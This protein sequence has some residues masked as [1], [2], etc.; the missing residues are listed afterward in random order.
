MKLFSMDYKDMTF[1]DAQWQHFLEAV[2]ILLVFFTIAFLAGGLGGCAY[3]S[4]SYPRCTKT[5][6][7]FNGNIYQEFQHAD[8]SYSI[9]KN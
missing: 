5:W 7:D 2:I 9:V 1:E 8:G 6:S 4:T 3:T